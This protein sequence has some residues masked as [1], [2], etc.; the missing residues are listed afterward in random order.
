[1]LIGEHA[2]SPGDYIVQK[3]IQNP[4]A[5]APL[6]VPVLV[7]RNTSTTDIERNIRINSGRDDLQ[8]ISAQPEHDTPL[9][10][11]GG[12]P[13]AADYLD[14]IRA[15]QAAGAHVFALNAA[16]LWLNH[17]G[18]KPDAQVIVDAQPETAAM[19]DPD[20]SGHLFGS[21]VHPDTMNAAPQPWVWH[22]GEDSEAMMPEARRNSGGYALIG[23]GAAVGT[24]A[25][26]LAY[27]MG[28][29]TLHIYGLDSSH[30][31]GRGHAYLQPA[32]DLIP[33]VDV[34]WAGR[35][36][37]ASVVMKAQAEWF[38]IIG[39]SLRAMGCAVNVYG[40][41]LLPA[42]FNTPV[43]QLSER[44]KYRLMW[45]LDLYRATSPGEAVVDEFLRIAEPDGLV[46]DFGCGTGRAGLKIAQ[47]GLPVFLIDFAD[48]ARDFA[49]QGLPFL[50][51]DLTRPVPVSGATGLCTDVME[52]IPGEDIDRV[53]TNIFAATPRVF[54]SIGTTPDCCGLLIGAT[55]HV[56]VLPHEVWAER[57]ARFGRIVFEQK[58]AQASIFYVE[59]A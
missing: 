29:R 38:Q 47:A 54:F 35:S 48:N 19:V 34:E 24:C 46:I 8:W 56:S 6:V 50:C 45:Q 30:R 44:D 3:E 43:D 40:D 36:Y 41:G 59:R 51:H 37:T 11:V 5:S 55:L 2:M 7:V 49:A 21:Q 20:A 4:H 57:L 32:N 12:G 26:C 42:M 53:L 23:G 17:H 28:Y 22:M 16:S 1:M 58:G 31:D 39:R 13:S 10:I 25:T 18:I 27:T 14:E 15:H 9:V 52:H 33:T